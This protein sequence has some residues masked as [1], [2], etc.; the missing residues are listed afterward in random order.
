M[1]D[2]VEVA[3]IDPFSDN[4]LGWYQT[5]IPYLQDQ[6]GVTIDGFNIVNANHPSDLSGELNYKDTLKLRADM[7][8]ETDESSVGNYQPYL[9]DNSTMTQSSESTYYTPFIPN[10]NY[11]SNLDN[12]TL[13]LNSTY[14]KDMQPKINLH[15]SIAQKNFFI[16]KKS[17]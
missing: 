5:T 4:A 10:Y 3:F 9:V 13:S 15:N 14:G 11:S 8:N 6:L 1:I 7:S 17:A 12:R 2:G 16:I